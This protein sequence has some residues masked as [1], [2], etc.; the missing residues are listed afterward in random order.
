LA[1]RYKKPI[2]PVDHLEGHIYACFAQ[3]QRGNPK[4]K[5]EFPFLALLV[6]GG[7]TS[8]VL[9][10][11]HLEYEIIA[12]TLDDAA[13]EA[14]DKAAKMM[15]LGYPG[16]P[17]I[18]DLSKKGNPEFLELPIPMVRQKTLNFSYSGLKTSFKYKL[19]KMSKK[20]I[21]EHLP[22]LAA[23]FQ[24]AVFNQIIDRL[25]KALSGQEPTFLVVGGGVVANKK[26]KRM[27][28]ELVKK[29]KIKAHFPY[30]DRLVGDNAAMIGVA[31]Y[32]KYQ[33]G[34]YL[35]DNFDRLDRVARSDLKIWVNKEV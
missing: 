32:F 29:K 14:L 11:N 27:I 18:E 17:I 3:N 16:G 6:S 33:K 35:K 30:S 21:A 1:E 31:A 5:F 12:R 8:L 15:G 13:G 28:R 22:D 4:R 9:V 24:E 25:E 23:S 19:E 34:I 10:K 20:K 26:L 2:I 7:H